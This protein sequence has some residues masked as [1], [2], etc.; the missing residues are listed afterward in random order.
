MTSRYSQLTSSR[1]TNRPGIAH[2]AF[3]L[4]AWLCP[5]ATFIL[6]QP[7]PH[8][9]TGSFAQLVRDLQ[10]KL[11]KIYGAG[12]YIGVTDWCSGVLVSPDGLILTVYSPTLDTENL[13]VHLY[14]G[15][16]HECDLVAAEP[17]LDV[18]LLR[19]RDGDK[20]FR[21]LPLEYFDLNQPTPKVQVGDWVLAFSNCFQIAT[22]EEPLTVQRS[23]IAAITPLAARRGIHEL[24]YQG[25]VYILDGITNNPGSHGGA[26]VTRRGELIGLIGKEVRNT[27]TETWVNYAIPIEALKDFVAKARAGNYKPLERKKPVIEDRGGFLGV[28]LVPNLL[29]RTPPYIDEVLPD[30]PA[31]KAGLR[32]D[33]LIVMV[34]LPARDGSG[35]Y[36]EHVVQSVSHWRDLSLPLE[37]GAKIQ[38][39]VRRQQ[40]LLRMDLEVARR[41]GF[42][43]NKP[44]ADK[45]ANQQ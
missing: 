23:V 35:T 21:D 18:A 37:P 2:G 19:I 27:L 16:R 39:I 14:D 12:G 28:V 7:L 9:H 6:A 38:V 13:R 5:W 34:R 22:R 29:D 32:P 15:T 33:D 24:P 44:A 8:P 41:P 10:P 42:R 25:T 17:L 40:Q 30:S 31:D 36:E 11:V 26:V 45:A 1:T 3:A 20:K 43:P 4:L